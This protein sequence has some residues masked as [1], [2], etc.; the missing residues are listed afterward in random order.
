LQTELRGLLMSVNPQVDF[1]DSELDW[2]VDEVGNLR[3]RQLA[4]A[5]AAAAAAA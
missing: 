5:A 1:K 4:E 2:I 3:K